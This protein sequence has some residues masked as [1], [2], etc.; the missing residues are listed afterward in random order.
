MD[1][2]AFA[3]GYA[4]VKSQV[5]SAVPQ[6]SSLKSHSKINFGQPANNNMKGNLAGFFSSL[7]QTLSRNMDPK[8]QGMWNYYKQ[9]PQN[10]L[11]LNQQ[12]SSYIK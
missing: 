2:E 1:K 9:T 10:V 4:S 3:Q 7:G 6:Q 12:K 8:F 11:S 5:P